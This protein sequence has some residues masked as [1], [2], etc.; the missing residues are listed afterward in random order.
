MAAHGP[1][2][3]SRVRS[4][5]R[6]ASRVRAVEQQRDADAVRVLDSGDACPTLPIIEQGGSAR[7]VVWPGVGALH[8]SMH[9]IR[10]DANA[11]TTPLSHP[12]DAVY[13]LCEGTATAADPEGGDSFDI[14]VGAMLHIDA[15]TTYRI[16]AGGEGALLVGGP[17]PPDP[18]MYEHLEPERAGG[19]S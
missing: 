4:S 8:R 9:V 18:A 19:D 1:V 10:L 6:G 12:S 17:C 13:H 16:E 15:G 11:A 5:I 2:R 3:M 14:E 7:A